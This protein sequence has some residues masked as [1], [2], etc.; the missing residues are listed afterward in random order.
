M[1]RTLLLASGS[2]VRLQMLSNAGLQVIA[3]PARV[4]E[5]AI[6][7]A[8]VESKAPARDIADTLAELKARKIAERTGD[9]LVL[10]CDQVL[11]FSGKIFEK[12]GS[13][14]EAR[15]QLRQLCGKVHY[16]Y[17]AAVLYDGPSP[18]WRHVGVARMTMRDLSDPWLDRYVD[19]NWNSIRYAVGGYLL[20]EEGVR[21]FCVI[22][23]DYF[24]VLGLPL[25]PLLNALID[26]GDLSA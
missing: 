19:R 20:E 16:L 12:P 23:G 14:D 25:L 3:Q 5:A 15:S 10:G 7:A 9:A 6:R 17:S 22:E 11:E 2:A 8:L 21:L 1:N 13:P 26:R 18:V 24:T 4:D